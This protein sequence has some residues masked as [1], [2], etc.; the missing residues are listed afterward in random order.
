[1]TNLTRKQKKL[2]KSPEK[3]INGVCEQLKQL[4]SSE[5]NEKSRNKI[6]DEVKK[7]LGIIKLV[8]FGVNDNKPNPDQVSSLARQ[9]Y[10]TDFFLLLISNLES[11][12]FESRK[13]VVQIFNNLLHRRLSTRLP[14]VEHI[15]NHKE[16]VDKLF[17]SYNQPEIALNCGMMLRE[18][19]HYETLAGYMLSGD[20]FWKLFE[21]VENT[22]FDVSSDTFSTFRDLLVVQKEVAAHFLVEQYDKF[23]KKYN[24]L[25]QT[26]YVVKRQSLKLLG[27]LLLDRKNFQVMKKYISDDENLKLMMNLMNDKRKS[28]QFEAF[29]VFKIFVANPNKNEKIIRILSMNKKALIKFLSHFL[30]DRNDETF[31]EEKLILIEEIRKIPS[32]NKK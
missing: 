28:I 8:L 30:E 18:C 14:T 2:K 12:E 5:L 26:S 9:V 16:I 10:N 19:V 11:L 7:F 25:L 17:E 20:N 21:Y 31:K 15:Y 3:L 32:K 24:L 6:I 1:M 22:N 23:F 4:G 29:H 27:E 13:D